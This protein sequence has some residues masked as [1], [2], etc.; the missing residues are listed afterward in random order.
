MT[1]GRHKSLLVGWVAKITVRSTAPCKLMSRRLADQVVKYVAGFV[2][3]ACIICAGRINLEVT[4]ESLKLIDVSSSSMTVDLSSKRV[5][6]V[7]PNST[8]PFVSNVYFESKTGAEFHV[9]NRHQVTSH[10]D[11]STAKTELPNISMSGEV[12]RGK[13]KFQAVKASLPNP[14][15]LLDEVVRLLLPEDQARR[16]IQLHPGNEFKFYLYDD[17]AEEYTW[18]NISACIDSKYNFPSNCDWGSSI[19][20][21][22]NVTNIFYSKRRFNRNGDVVVAKVLDEYSGPLRTKDPNEADLFIVPYPSAGNCECREVVYR[23]IQNIPI[24]ELKDKLI[25]KLKFYN[26]HTKTKHLFLSSNI[27]ID[28]HP[29]FRKTTVAPLGT[30]LG[31]HRCNLLENCGRLVVPYVST[32]Q[33]NQP[34]VLH[35]NHA[36]NL[37]E[38][39]YALTAFMARKISGNSI[40]RV[41]F[42]DMVSNVS[43]IAGRP[44][45]VSSL[46]GRAITNNEKLIHGMYRDSVFC[47]CFR[48]DE[49]PQKRIFDVI[50]SGCIPVVLQH[51][52]SEEVGWPSH[53]APFGRSIRQT[54]PFS[55][56]NFYNYSDMG[57][58]FR[59]MVVELSVNECGMPCLVQTLEEMLMRHPE[60]IIEK[61]RSIA[62]YASLL[63]FG[64]EENGLKHPD[65]VSA[66]LVQ[67]RH[68]LI[69]RHNS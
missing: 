26:A 24:H 66:M 12:P 8:A 50:L 14:K 22:T 37:D 52:P 56:G 7:A 42:F 64:M 27:W 30:I 31:A 38:R 20:T 16:Y 65:A 62:K 67:A 11:S 3:F 4:Q 36:K 2:I 47:S 55:R 34:N 40:D 48:G 63:S 44:I 41:V 39:K 45:H 32:I 5:I 18:K 19:C 6:S 57:I 68:Y 49:P 21:E 59:D 33:E 35:Q 28:A 61:Q 51:N 15:S 1:A 17:L 46:H 54:Y 60:L 25:K 13:S 10:G 58:E 9:T 23:C 69:H 43:E 29:T 53:F